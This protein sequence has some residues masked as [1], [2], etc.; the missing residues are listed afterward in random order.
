[1]TTHH[2]WRFA[3]V[4]AATVFLGIFSQAQSSNGTVLD[5]TG[6][7]VVG[8]SVQIH[9]PV[10]GYNRSTTTDTSGHFS[11]TNVPLNPYHLTVKATGFNAFVQDVE[12]RSNVPVEVPIT[13]EV[14]AAKTEVTVEAAGDLLE[15]EP[16]FHTDIDKSLIEKIP[17]ESASSPISS[18]VTLSTPGISA[19]SNGLFHGMGDHAENSF[20][21]DGQ[22]ISD[23]QSKVFSNQI[24]VD[25]IESVEVIRGAPSA[26]YGDKTSLVIVVTTRSGMGVT[27]PH[28]EVTGTFGSFASAGGG[29]NLA[30]G[31]TAFGNFISV[32]GMD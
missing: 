24:P 3:A 5:P 10:S 25:A 18:I 17:L 29:F 20:S 22:P 27:Q 9:N 7:V 32:S 21:V 15:T 11:F 28:G 19:D 16:T 26:E 4:A 14:T 8:A 6:A 23:Q 2:R 13:L 1:M 12:V 30:T 31:G